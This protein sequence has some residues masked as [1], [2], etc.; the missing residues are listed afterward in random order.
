MNCFVFNLLL[1]YLL[2]APLNSSHNN[3][4]TTF[5]WTGWNN[6]NLL[7]ITLLYYFYFQ[8]SL[9]MI[10]F[11]SKI[12]VYR[13]V[14]DK[15]QKIPKLQIPCFAIFINPLYIFILHSWWLYYHSY[16][17]SSSIRASLV[18]F[19]KDVL[20]VRHNSFCSM[21]F[22]SSTTTVALQIYTQPQYSI[23]VSVV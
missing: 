11:A 21:E 20:H 23:C 8:N 13:I 10:H 22:G 18:T 3:S 16:M 19:S 1:H 6:Q 5:T 7:A 15:L 17:F 12:K 2:R 4:I 14:T 9:S